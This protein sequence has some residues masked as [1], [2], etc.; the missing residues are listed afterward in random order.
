MP[1]FIEIFTYFCTKEQ[2]MTDNRIRNI[3]E[4]QGITTA[5]LA[6][7]IGMTPSGLNQHISGNPSVKT[8]EKIAEG[9]N[10]PLW[11]LF[12]SEDKIVLD[13]KTNEFVSFFRYKGIHYTSDTLEEFF[14]QVEELR[15]IAK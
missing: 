12:V 11:S 3:M 8:L 13:E 5:V 10:V 9:L 2:V 7:K 4:E 1:C 14:K 15:I 6:K